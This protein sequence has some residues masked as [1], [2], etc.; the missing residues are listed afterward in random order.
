M[1]EVAGALSIQV[2]AYCLEARNGGMRI[3]TC[4]NTNV[5]NGSESCS[6]PYYEVWAFQVGFESSGL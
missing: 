4:L 2:G 5:A 3:N 6:F 1:S